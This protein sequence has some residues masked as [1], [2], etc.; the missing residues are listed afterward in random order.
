[1]KKDRKLYYGMFGIL[2]MIWGLYVCFPWNM[3]W[4]ERIAR[5]IYVGVLFVFGY[6]NWRS[7][8]KITYTST[9]IVEKSNI[10][11]SILT[12]GA[13]ILFSFVIL[14]K[15][16]SYDHFIVCFPWA[17]S[18]IAILMYRVPLILNEDKIC[19]DGIW[20]MVKEVESVHIYKYSKRHDKVV[21]YVHGRVKQIIA[22]HEFKEDLKDFCEQK[23]IPLF[24]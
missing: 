2:L 13:A 16:F 20:Y 1:M 4:F 14:I 12:I 21:F 22:N 18:F 5:L 10:K 23:Q 17:Y 3:D 24:L 6:R 7:H 8:Q 11:S 15:Q 19:V 9:M